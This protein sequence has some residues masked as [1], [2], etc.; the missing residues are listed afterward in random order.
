MSLV[1]VPVV[2]KYPYR[3]TGATP[4]A[5]DIH[6]IPLSPAIVD[7][8]SITLP[9]KLICT[10]NATGEVPA[11][12]TLPTVGDG[13]FYKVIEKFAGGRGGNNGYVIQVLTTHTQI[14]LATVV[15]AIPEIPF[16]SYLSSS[17]I[18]ISIV[19]MAAFNSLDARVGVLELG[20]VGGAGVTDG[21]KGDITVSGAGTVWTVDAGLFD[22]FGAASTAQAYAVQRANHT[23]TQSLDTTTDSATR[24]AMA[25]AERTKLGAIA[26]GATANATD[27]QLRDR[28]T[29]TGTQLAATVS[30]FNTAADARITAQ[31]GAAFGLAPLASDSKIDTSF[32]PSSVLGQVSYQ[33]L[34]NATTAAPAT[35]KG[36]YYIVSVA[37]TTSLS[38][39]TDWQ[40]G[41][42]A[43]YDGSAWGKVD[44]TD[45]VSSVAGKTGV[46]TLVKGD[47]GLGSVDN[48]A[49]SA[50]PV[51]TAQGAADTAVQAY[52][53]QRGNHTGT[54][55]A[56]TIS[57]FAET[58]LA[59]VLTGLSLATSTAVTAADTILAAIGKLQAQVTLRAT[60]AS[61]TFT[62]T[63]A[64][65]TATVNTNT[66]QLATTAFVQAAA[67]EAVT[68]VTPVSGVATLNFAGKSY[69]SFTIALGANITSIVFTNLPGA[70]FVADYD[71]LMTQDATGS[72]T[73][74]IPASHKALGG[75][76]TS[77]NAAA[78]TSTL[79]SAKTFDNGTT[80][81]YAMQESA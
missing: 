69:A 52:A 6:F 64:A 43:I 80:W 60:L 4:A 10:L 40:V 42:W 32:L 54:Q 7:G 72:R 39:I 13:V 34:W 49:D 36:F 25:P 66:T 22:A 35:G 11:G 21:D 63:P 38:G 59:G 18:G 14:D 33:G 19:G 62:G 41:D 15:P 76:D 29:H 56:A 28:S 5:G 17:A 44:N 65:P 73:V 3:D 47:V 68:A 23:G 50:K 1:H 51:S 79:L 2:G 27:A 16:V 26:T 45:A 8:E 75:S 74:A 9:K 58:V 57:D 53:V 71:L 70:G 77:V 81:R 30:D 37:G 31:K 48:T 24:V 55:L 67:K 61:P 78:N 12:F 20:G 46:V